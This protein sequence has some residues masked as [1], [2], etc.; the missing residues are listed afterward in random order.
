MNQRSI[1]P[2]CKDILEELNLCT[3]CHINYQTILTASS[4]PIFYHFDIAL[5]SESILLQ[6][7]DLVF[8]N[9]SSPPCKTMHD[10]VDGAFYRNE[11]KEETDLFITLTMNVNGVQP[12]KGSDSSIWPLLIV[13]DE[14]RR[15]K[16]YSLENVMLAGIWPG[17]KKPSRNEMTIFLQ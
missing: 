11:L 14:I 9:L 16:R 2:S 3:K 15:R 6:T 17:P 12:H 5:Q 13:I 1:C 10:I 7:F 4:I 8:Q